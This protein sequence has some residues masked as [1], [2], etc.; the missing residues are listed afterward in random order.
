M[1]VILSYNEAMPLLREADVLLFRNPGFPSIGWAICAY[2]K[3]IHS[4]VGMVSLSCGDPMLIEQREFKGGRSVSLET[5][6]NSHGI[7][8]YRICPKI[9]LPDGTNLEF[10]DDTALAITSTARHITGKPY[11]WNNIWGI[12]KTYAPFIRLL[13]AG[14]ESSD[15]KEANAFVCS[16]VVAHSYRRHFTDLCPTLPD[17][18][19]TPSDLPR[20][21]LLRYMFTIKG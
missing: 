6:I 15:D 20:S 19:T 7:D 1:T 2:T 18:V 16:T 13:Y 14:K 11:G 12:F 21:G 10:S 4:H 8:V 5:Q 3:G 9:T 17:D